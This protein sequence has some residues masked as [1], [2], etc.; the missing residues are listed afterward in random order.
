[1]KRTVSEKCS[2]TGIDGKRPTAPL[3]LS[4]AP[5]PLRDEVAAS[6]GTS[7]LDAPKRYKRILAIAGLKAW[8]INA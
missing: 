5:L 7:P 2:V 3:G 6:L 4:R 1:M 8:H